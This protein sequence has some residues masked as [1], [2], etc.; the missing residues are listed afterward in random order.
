MALLYA[1]SLSQQKTL[2]VYNFPERALCLTPVPVWKSAA[3]SAKL[4]LPRR[5]SWM[6]LDQARAA[7]DLDVFRGMY[8]VFVR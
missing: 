6:N 4:S 8:E 1:K 5:L 7:S 3:S 2:D